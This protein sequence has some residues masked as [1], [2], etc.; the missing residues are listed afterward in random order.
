MENWVI[1]SCRNYDQSV[2]NL[3]NQA[4]TLGYIPLVSSLTGPVRAMCGAV[5]GMIGSVGGTLRTVQYLLTRN[6]DHKL[7]AMAN[8]TNLEHGA[9]NATRGSIESMPVVGNVATFV[10]DNI[11]GLR[12]N[13]M[14][15]ELNGKDALC[16]HYKDL[17]RMIPADTAKIIQVQHLF[18]PADSSPKA[19]PA[20]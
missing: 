16:L 8:L 4:N 9:L 19:A 13:Y 20:A 12:V 17:Q 6:A 2:A 5:Q 10:Y 15:E 18:F 14:Y 1:N 11:L 3:E 7:L